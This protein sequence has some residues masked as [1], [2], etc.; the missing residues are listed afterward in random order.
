MLSQLDC[1]IF[2]LETIK[3]Q[4]AHDD[5]FKDVLLNCKEGKTWNKFV[6]TNGFVF[7]ANKLCIPASSVR[8]LLLQEAH[9]G[10]LMGHFGVKK[11]EDILADHF[12]WP[13]MRRDVERFVARCITCQK[14]KTRLNPHGLYMP[15]PVPNA[16]WEDILMDFVL[17]LPRTKKGRDSVLWLWIDF[18][19][20]HVSYHVIRP[21]MLLKLLICSFMKLFVCMVCQTQLFQIVM[22]NFLVIFGELC[23]LN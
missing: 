4:Y 11:T 12:F 5:D 20:W 16:P 10:G 1:K 13:K 7:R 6:L 3:A 19:R 22:Q 23:G 8:L 15:L 18:L 17:G 9:G 2:G 21:I 14:A